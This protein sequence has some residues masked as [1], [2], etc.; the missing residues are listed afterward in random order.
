ML[1]AHQRSQMPYGVMREV[2]MRVRSHLI[3][4]A[5][6][7]VGASALAGPEEIRRAAP[8]AAALCQ[9]KFGHKE[10]AGRLLGPALVITTPAG[11]NDW[12]YMAIVGGEI[13]DAPKSVFCAKEAIVARG[14]Y[15]DGRAAADRVWTVTALSWPDGTVRRNGELWSVAAHMKKR[16]ESGIASIDAR[17]LEPW[18]YV[19]GGQSLVAEFDS[20]A[21]LSPDGK[22]VVAERTK[23][24]KRISGT[25][26]LA[27]PSRAPGKKLDRYPIAF[28]ADGRVATYG[29]TL[30]FWDVTTGKQAGT[31]PTTDY[32]MLSRDGQR[33]V[34]LDTRDEAAQGVWD[35]A[36]G[37][38]LSTLA[39]ARRE[40][41]TLF[42]DPSALSRDGRLGCGVRRQ[43]KSS[44]VLWDLT[45]DRQ[46]ADL[47]FSVDPYA[48][49]CAVSQD[50]QFLVV[51]AHGELYRLG[52]DGR[53]PKRRLGLLSAKGVPCLALSKTGQWLGVGVWGHIQLWDIAAGRQIV[54]EAAQERQNCRVQFT[55]DDALLVHIVTGSDGESQ[56][57][58]WD[59]ARL[60]GSAKE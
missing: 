17:E 57:R 50:G 8:E 49:A 46:A 34:N 16:S 42:R 10:E 44:L 19:A 54:S 33:Y 40:H 59:V 29:K 38:R 36:S 45:E 31:L 11:T 23:A 55:P 53:E 13:G 37:R 6:V 30:T 15:T 43:A 12:K 7:A 26:V 22:T 52:V 41:V 56:T 21:L 27:W 2:E 47:T 48:D 18:L 60:A 51:S 3:T 5:L 25:D 9:Q 35:I 20:K 58:F 39:G 24:G 14:K 1:V 4:I 28:L 32:G